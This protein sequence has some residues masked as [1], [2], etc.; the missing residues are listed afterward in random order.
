MY[1]LQKPM[2]R[3]LLA[4][5]F[6]L[7]AIS[8]V[9]AQPLEHA[10]AS[11]SLPVGN[12]EQ[13]KPIQLAVPVTL[14]A[15]GALCKH[16]G[17]IPGNGHTNVDDYIQYI[18]AAAN[19]GLGLCG[20]RGAH[21][22]RERIALTATAY[23]VMLGL[24]QGLKY[25]IREQRPDSDALTSFPSG[26][27]A[28]AFTGAELVRREYGNG[29]GLAAYGIATTV[30]FLRLYNHRHWFNDLIGGVGV[31]LL[32]VQA[33]YWLLPL[34]RRLFGWDKGG[35]AITVVPGYDGHNATLATSITF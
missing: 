33:A 9:A 32:S 30:A 1:K 26:H 31:G 34:E 15:V 17:R 29:Y 23:A 13:F 18:P 2:H 25:T 5:G 10:I 8:L 6:W 22:W 19:I 14:I 11:D 35:P 4:V 24:S 20:V 21:P 16:N 28:T 7:L 12:Q 27:T 3:F